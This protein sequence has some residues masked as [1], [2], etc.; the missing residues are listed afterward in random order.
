MGN[1]VDT[2][3]EIKMEVMQVDLKP[4][5]TYTGAKITFM[6]RTELAGLCHESD[7]IIAFDH[8]FCIKTNTFGRTIGPIYVSKLNG[9]LSKSGIRV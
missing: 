8:D 3:C 5:C 9:L 6:T 7:H 2:Q 1:F 4:L